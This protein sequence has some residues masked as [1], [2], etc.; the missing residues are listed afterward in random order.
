MNKKSLKQY[1]REKLRHGGYVQ[2]LTESRRNVFSGLVEREELHSMEVLREERLRALTPTR[3][4]L[5]CMA[6]EPDTGLL[7]AFEIQSPN[8]DLD[9]SDNA[10]GTADADSVTQE[11]A[12]LHASNVLHASQISEEIVE[13]IKSGKIKDYE[14]MLGLIPSQLESKLVLPHVEQAMKPMLRY[15]TL[16][17]SFATGGHSDL[18]A[19]LPSRKTHLV[20]AEIISIDKHKGGTGAVRFK[21]V[22]VIDKSETIPDT[23]LPSAEIE[24]L[25]ATA[26]IFRTIRLLHLASFFDF[27][28]RLE[29]QLEYSLSSGR[30]TIRIVAFHDEESLIHSSKSVQEVFSDW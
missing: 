18:R 12:A 15:E 8:G 24:A 19:F 23:L 16:A 26:S 10:S 2:I 21:V 13:S 29:L 28:P 1:V 9:F 5:L 22:D 17:G 7:G 6:I 27:C 14:S 3:D 25:I 11:I 4:K 20:Q 30:W